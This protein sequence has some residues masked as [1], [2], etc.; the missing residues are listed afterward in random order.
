MDETQMDENIESHEEGA[1][2]NTTPMTGDDLTTKSVDESDYAA[3]PEF[4]ERIGG[5]DTDAATDRDTG[6]AAMPAEDNRSTL[7]K[8]RDRLTGE[9]DEGY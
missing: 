7:E 4:G 8:V 5:T 2:A 3:E 9:D 1:A 6:E